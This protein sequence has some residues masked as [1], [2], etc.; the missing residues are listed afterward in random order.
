MVA[1][2]ADVENVGREPAGRKQGRDFVNSVV[3]INRE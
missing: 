1:K 2:V 3:R